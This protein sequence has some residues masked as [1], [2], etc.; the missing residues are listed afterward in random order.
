MQ[1]AAATGD[2]AAEAPPSLQGLMDFLE[3]DLPHL[4]D[5]QGIDPSRY[6]DSVRF[7]DPI[8]QYD[9]IEGYLFNIQM[10]RRLFNPKFV[11]HNV[12][13]TGEAEV[14][15]R[16]TMEMRFW[17]L[18]WNPE[19]VF[20]GTS[21]MSVDLAT[22][23]FTSHVDTWDS[24][25]NQ[26]Y[27][28][29]EAVRDLVKNLLPTAGLTPD[30]ETPRYLV[31]KRTADYEVRRYDDFLVAEVGTT[32]DG[33]IS[34]DGFN[35]LAGYIFGGNE[36]NVS[37]SM[38]TP[39]YTEPG[40]MQFPL[41]GSKFGP[42]DAAKAPAPTADGIAVKREDNGALVAALK[43]PGIPL[44]ADVADAERR[45]RGALERDGLRA[46]GGCRVARYNEPTQLPAFKRNEVLV[47]VE[48]FEL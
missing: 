12:K 47:K 20:T 21:I 6:S 31:L 37:M 18:P 15:T 19:V 41:E 40:A 35:R 17:L 9:S 48:G 36:E 22:M 45:L 2:A 16:W 5:E 28:S 23:Q 11:L 46:A 38:T 7:T 10:L 44:D 34:G 14:T 39:V 30:L 33:M 13:Q 1:E 26:E 4:F 42:G 29:V 3:A 32:D 8:T 25:E 24:I 43:F 27:L